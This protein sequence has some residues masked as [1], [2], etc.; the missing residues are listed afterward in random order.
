MAFN[1]FNNSSAVGKGFGAS[2]SRRIDDL[3]AARHFSL[4]FF[5]FTSF[6]FTS[7][8]RA[9]RTGPTLGELLFSY[10]NQLSFY[11]WL[12]DTAFFNVDSNA[13]GVQMFTIP[14]TGSYRITSRGGSG[15]FP[16]EGNSRVGRAAVVQATFDFTKGD[17]MRIVVGQNGLPSS[18]SGSTSYN[19]GGGGGSYLFYALTDT[20]PLL[21]AG[22]G[23]GGSYSGNSSLRPDAANDFTG[24]PGFYVTNEGQTRGGGALV[25]NQTLG[26]GGYNNNSVNHKAG[27]GAGWKGTGHGGHTLCSPQAP[28]HVQGGWHK[29]KTLSTASNT[30]NGGPFMG[31]WGGASSPGNGSYQGGFGGGG[32]GTGRCGSCQA[33]GGGGYSGGGISTSS[34]T[35][36]TKESL[37]GGGNYVHSS[38]SS[39]TVAGYGNPGN[40]GYVHFQKV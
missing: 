33:G 34:D 11:D 16:S 15:G 3:D 28:Y 24:N 35:S 36:P 5:I 37:A 38:A 2:T 27:S 31:G 14:Q 7:A 26:F 1:Y 18:S 19:S 20:E 22:G 39:S 30:S 17:V 29:G 10:P 12:N 32:G 25:S 40:T 21:V 6:T 9:G 4:T 8:G 23:G 13:Q